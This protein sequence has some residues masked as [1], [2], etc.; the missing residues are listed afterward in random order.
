[1]IAGGRLWT[2]PRGALFL[3]LWVSSAASSQ[4]PTG[5]AATEPEVVA[6]PVPQSSEESLA[7]P[8]EVPEWSKDGYRHA[9]GEAL[10]ALLSRSPV[11]STQ[12]GDHRFDDK[13]PD[14]SEDGARKTAEEY[15]ARA[16]ELRAF[17]GSVP[18]DLQGA[19]I[20]DAGTDHPALDARLLA[21]HL[22]ALAV[23]ESEVGRL[24]KD[25]SAVVE[26]VG[27]GMSSLTAH[28]Y[29]PARVRFTAL[30]TRLEAV[31]AMV[32]VARGR[33]KKA[34]RAGY[35]NLLVSG[36]G[37]ARSL[38]TELAKIDVRALDGD[39][40]LTDRVRAS[41][42]AAAG[43][44]EAYVEDVKKSFPV[45][46]LDSTPIGATLWA[47]LARLREGVN[48]SPAAVRKMGE[49]E[50]ERLT[51]ELDE[52]IDASPRNPRQGAARSAPHGPKDRAAF[53]R[54]L[55]SSTLP[56]DRILAEYHFVNRGVE[57]WLK[58]HPF[59]TVPWDR[60]RVTVVQTP[61]QKRGLSFAS[62]NAAGPLDPT[63]SDAHFE[64]NAPDPSMP[65]VQRDEPP[66]PSI[67]VGALDLVSVHEAHPGTLPAGPRTSRCAVPGA[68]GHMGSDASA[69]AGPTTAS[70]RCSMT[71]TP[72]R[73]PLRT[74][75]FYLRMALQRA[76]RVV[77]DVGENDGSLTFDAGAKLLEDNA[78]LAPEAAK[79]EARRALVAPAN[80]FCYTYGKL[81]IL[82]LREAVKAREGQASTSG[83]PRSAPVVGVGPGALRRP[84]G[85]FGRR[86]TGERAP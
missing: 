11:W 68:E 8:P 41:A 44:L 85:R 12:R 3:A 70:R 58:A 46:A 22:E 67:R 30:A 64:V 59:V 74:Q 81:A 52:L 1:M 80:M 86:V 50:L 61:P 28:E 21:D 48:D 39:Q 73:D 10:L 62:M 4:A 51:R 45:K 84:D 60:A 49:A 53:L 17:A 65:P 83:V 34:T 15:R 76:A 26:L 79:I 16:V 56:D 29:A 13:W 42:L 72:A 63:A 32:K 38:R 36:P 54:L 27:E 40:A 69:R 35:E 2:L 78:L 19:D 33:L 9:L 37:I 23:E 47:T 6:P 18:A 5:C 31:P 24:E 77:I 82:R 25:P 66:A 7:A 71:A 14:L 75:A 57:A 55:G 43:A 20:D